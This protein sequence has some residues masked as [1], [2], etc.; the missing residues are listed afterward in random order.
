[1]YKNWQ[2]LLCGYELP[3]NKFVKFYTKKPNRSENIPKCLGATFLKY[4]VMYF[5]TFISERYA[6]LFRSLFR[7]F[8]CNTFELGINRCPESVDTVCSAMNVHLLWRK[9][10]KTTRI[11]FPEGGTGIWKKSRFSLCLSGECK[12]DNRKSYMT[13]RM[14]LIS[15]TLND[16]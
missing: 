15:I 13:Y 2:I 1:M 16:P 3:T 6:V 9:Q 5:F 4:P 8:A 14:A 11:R 12:T 10:R 7:L